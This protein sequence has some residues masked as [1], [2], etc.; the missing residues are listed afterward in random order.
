MSA[1]YNATP[2]VRTR[3]SNARP[4]F[5]SMPMSLD[6][7]SPSSHAASDSAAWAACLAVFERE[8]TPQQFKTW[9]RPLAC[10][11][12]PTAGCR[13]L[14]PNRFVLQWVKERFGGRIDALAREAAGDAVALEFAVADARPRPP[15]AAPAAAG[16]R[17]KAAGRRPCHPLPRRPPARPA[18]PPPADGPPPRRKPTRDRAS[19]PAS[20]SHSFVAGK[21]NQLA[22][23]AGMQVAEHPTS[24]NPLFVYGGVG[25]GK[26]HLIQAIGNHI[27]QQQSRR[28]RSATSMPKPTSPTSCAPTSTRRSTTSSATT[29]R[30]TCC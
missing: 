9:I 2:R 25:L 13:L 22:R 10:S 26:T 21:A 28:A 20:R 11:D 4:V 30:S 1:R 24:Y 5:P 12:V 8:L 27:L 23:A 29:A 3:A 14:A 15:P 7:Q 17:P 6:R 18:Q 19:I 16:A